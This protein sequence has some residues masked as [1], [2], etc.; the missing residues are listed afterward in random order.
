MFPTVRSLS[1]TAAAAA[2]GA[3][4][5]ALWQ[6]GAHAATSTRAASFPAPPPGATVY[7]RELGYDALA[8]GVVPHGRSVLVQASVLGRQGAGVAGLHF[9]FTLQGLTKAAVA[10]GPGC[11]RATLSV[12]SAPHLLEVRL[13][14]NALRWAIELPAAWPPRDAAAL[15][16]RAGRVWRALRSL[17]FRETLAS[18]PTAGLTSTWRL[19]A[20]DRLAYQVQGGWAGVV[21][22]ARRWDRAPGKT[23]WKV[24][25]QTRLRQPV[26]FWV[27]VAD[28]HVLGTTTVNGRPAWRVSFFDPGSPAWFDVVI[29]R[30]TRRTLES[31]MVTTAHFMHDVYSSFDSTSPIVPPR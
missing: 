12:G 7:S 20:P 3:A 11:Y 1:A 23:E 4:T 21:I 10:C 6:P 15:L 2:L 8:V 27:S 14:G 25:A 30:A 22:G 19:Q 16:G 26:P 24:S 13:R 29:D 28:A 5:L 31:R 18:G 9:S 17:T